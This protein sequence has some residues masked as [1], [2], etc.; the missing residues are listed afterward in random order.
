VLD[1]C[2][3]AEAFVR[4]VEPFPPQSISAAVQSGFTVCWHAVEGRQALQGAT[5]SGAMLQRILDL[6]GVPARERDELEKAALN[7]EPGDLKVQG[8]GLTDDRIELTGIGPGV[9][10]ARVWRAALEAAA[11]AG[12]DVLARMAEIAGP[13]KRLMA[14]GGWAE[15]VATQAVKE[16]HLGPFR[17]VPAIY[18]GAQGAA[19]AAGRATGLWNDK[20]DH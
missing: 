13:A 6:L 10:P 7:E 17:H 19:I 1:S 3:T 20:E 5:A 12:A 9:S 15:G 14:T 2:G 4:T 8:L 11:A 16:Q 18:A